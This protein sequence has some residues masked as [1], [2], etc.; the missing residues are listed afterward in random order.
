MGRVILE[1]L[2]SD[3]LNEIRDEEKLLIYFKGGVMIGKLGD[4]ELVG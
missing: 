2:F 1:L 3:N 4:S